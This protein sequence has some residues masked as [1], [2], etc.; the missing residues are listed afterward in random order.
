MRVALQQNPRNRKYARGAI[1]IPTR[2]RG[3][4]LTRALRRM[5][6]VWNDPDVFFGIE[7]AEMDSY[8]TVLEACPK[9]RVVEV[10]NPSGAVGVARETV[11]RAATAVGYPVYMVM[12]DNVITTPQ[13]VENLI[14]AVVE[15]PRTCVMGGFHPTANLYNKAQIEEAVCVN[16]IRSYWTIAF[17]MYA[18]P[19]ALYDGFE[20]DP[21]LTQYDDRYHALWVLRQ[22]CREFRACIDAP[23]TKARGQAGGRSGSEQ[24]NGEAFR[25]LINEFADVIGKAEFSFPWKQILES[26]DARSTRRAARV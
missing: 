10:H 15:F 16:G 2:N 18:F 25:I 1:L 20:Y 3:E 14:R 11:R 12:D 23:F 5:A 6:P 22:G 26:Y 7:P 19:S 9:A 8:R 13:A 4:L 21:G 24:N 17:M